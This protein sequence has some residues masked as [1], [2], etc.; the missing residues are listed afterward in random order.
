MST[1]SPGREG[2]PIERGLNPR[3]RV[4]AVDVDEDAADLPLLAFLDVI[5]QVDLA[6]FFEE[7][8]L[9]LDVG[10]HVALAAVE[11]LEPLEV[12]VHLGLFEHLSGRQRHAPFERRIG[13]DLV[14]DV[15]HVADLVAR[16]LVD[17]RSG[18]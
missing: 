8:R 9:G 16:A 2:E 6:R 3:V 17:R 10:E 13:K 18:A 14:A 11:V 12:V 4:V 5:D 1:I 15:G 7:H